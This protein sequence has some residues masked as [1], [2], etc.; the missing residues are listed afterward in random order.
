MPATS[1]GADRAA[2]LDRLARFGALHRLLLHFREAGL[3]DDMPEDFDLDA[4][5]CPDFIAEMNALSDAYFSQDIPDA[6]GNE[7]PD[8]SLNHA[9]ENVMLARMLLGLAENADAMR[10]EAR[11]VLAFADSSLVNATPAVAGTE[12]RN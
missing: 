2:D 3:L 9:H 7:P 5:E 11:R 12:R 4:I 1:V 8:W 6:D 10:H